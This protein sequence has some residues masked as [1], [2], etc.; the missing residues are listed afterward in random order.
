MCWWG[1]AGQNVENMEEYLG[2]LFWDYWFALETL[3]PVFPVF[4]Y[5][6]RH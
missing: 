3:L 5:S 2:L 1:T 6:R 4:L